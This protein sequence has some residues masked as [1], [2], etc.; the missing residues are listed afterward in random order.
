MTI[1]RWTRNAGLQASRSAPAVMRSV[2]RGGFRL[3]QFC[4][5]SAS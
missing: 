3:S 2:P 5:A 4:P 1:R